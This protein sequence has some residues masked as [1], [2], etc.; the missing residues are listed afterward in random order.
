MIYEKPKR[1]QVK[2]SWLFRTY[3]ESDL[4]GHL[5]SIKTPFM[6]FKHRSHYQKSAYQSPY[7][8]NSLFG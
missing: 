5:I 2:L 7:D 4:N 8:L 3:R 6:D 1:H